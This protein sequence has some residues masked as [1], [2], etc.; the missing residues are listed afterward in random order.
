MDTVDDD[1]VRRRINTLVG[2][3]LPREVPPNANA[4]TGQLQQ[5]RWAKIVIHSLGIGLL[6]VSLVFVPL[7][8]G[9]WPAFRWADRLMGLFASYCLVSLGVACILNPFREIRAI[10]VGIVPGS[11]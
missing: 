4:V 10:Q 2:W 8:I 3:M 6:A 5:D 1:V 11:G 9:G 7:L